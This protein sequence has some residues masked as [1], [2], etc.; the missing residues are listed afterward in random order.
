MRLRWTEPAVQ[1]LQNI[2][3]YVS[4]HDGPAAARKIALRIYEGL[5]SLGQFPRRRESIGR[6]PETRELVI[7]GLPWLA[8]YRI[9]E[10]VTEVN[11]ILHGGEHFQ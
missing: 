11:R 9:R 6:K 1:Y 2:C 3:D 4:E 7:S 10:D 8:I 5:D